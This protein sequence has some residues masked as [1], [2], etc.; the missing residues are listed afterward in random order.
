M[1]LERHACQHAGVCPGGSRAP[2][3]LCFHSNSA[4]SCSLLA[5]VDLPQKE[6]MSIQTG[7]LNLCFLPGTSNDKE[8]PPD[9]FCLNYSFSVLSYSHPSLP[10]TSLPSLGLG[11]LTPGKHCH[12]SFGIWFPSEPERHWLKAKGQQQKETGVFLF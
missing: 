5:P 9:L 3:G 11:I 4:A 6:E 1:A 10:S 2:S 12:G 8:V 7:I